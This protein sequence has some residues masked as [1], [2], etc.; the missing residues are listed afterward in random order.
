MFLI[1][2]VTSH[3]LVDTKRHAELSRWFATAKAGLVYVSAFQN[4]SVM[5]RYL[6]EIAWGTVGWVADSPSHLVHFNGESLPMPVVRCFLL[7]GQVFHNLHI[8]RTSEV[9]CSIFIKSLT[10]MFMRSLKK[11]VNPI[12]RMG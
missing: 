6:S 1:E 9:L 3:G 10:V 12:I 5:A 4:R 2:A 7:L 8:C 11:V